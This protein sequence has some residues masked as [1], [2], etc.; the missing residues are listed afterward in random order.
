MKPHEHL[1]MYRGTARIV[2]LTVTLQGEPV[3]IAGYTL[4]FLAVLA[5]PYARLT[6]TTSDGSIS[7]TDAP[8]GK[9]IFPIQPAM[10]SSFPNRKLV[11]VYQ[12]TGFDAQGVPVTLEENTL[13]ILPNL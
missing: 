10:T 5:S 2:E 9:A 3:N 6:G 7:I 13:R 8:N 1:W 4:T 12:W 11:L